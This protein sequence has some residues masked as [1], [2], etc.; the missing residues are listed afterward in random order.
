[1]FRFVLFREFFGLRFV[2]RLFQFVIVG[3]VVVRFLQF[4]VVGFVIL[5]VV[6]AG[7]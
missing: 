4:V 6:V 7:V 3:F 5:L 2:L 1:L